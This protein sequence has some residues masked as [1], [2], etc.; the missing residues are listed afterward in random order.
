MAYL[1]ELS[2]ALTVRQLLLPCDVDAEI[3]IYQIHGDKLVCLEKITPQSRSLALGLDLVPIRDFIH[4]TPRW[5]SLSSSFGPASKNRDPREPPARHSH[6]QLGLR[7]RS[8][9]P[10]CV[11]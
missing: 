7:D 10:I 6:A 1:T 8:Y 3:Y 9:C 2:L 11:T 4:E 5:N